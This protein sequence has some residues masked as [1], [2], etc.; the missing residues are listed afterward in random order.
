MGDNNLPRM[1]LFSLAAHFPFQ[2]VYHQTHLG[3]AQTHFESCYAGFGLVMDNYK[4][5][6]CI[7]GPK[8]DQFS[9]INVYLGHSGEGDYETRLNLVLIKKMILLIKT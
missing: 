8:V 2:D 5:K 7:K 9:K 6:M 3:A 1:A 4:S